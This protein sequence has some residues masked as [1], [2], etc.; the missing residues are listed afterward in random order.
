METKKKTRMLFCRE[1][2]FFSELRRG[3][4]SRHTRNLSWFRSPIVVRAEV[5]SRILRAGSAGTV[6]GRGLRRASDERAT[7]RVCVRR[8][9]GSAGDHSRGRVRY[10]RRA[11]PRLRRLQ[12]NTLLDDTRTV[13]IFSW[14]VG[15][16]SHLRPERNPC[17]VDWC[18]PRGTWCRSSSRPRTWTARRV[19]LQA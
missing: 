4:P 17:R 11:H 8:R 16:R 15:H 12:K 3:F 19:N 9:R 2:L 5:T 1:N 10:E 14:G 18:S 6:P 13:I 7:T